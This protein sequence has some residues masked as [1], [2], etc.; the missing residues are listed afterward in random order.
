MWSG[1]QPKCTTR[2]LLK[3]ITL[4]LS[5]KRLVGVLT[6]ILTT[7]M[8]NR[9][10]SHSSD[11]WY[12]PS[13]WMSHSIRHSLAELQATAIFK[14]GLSVLTACLDEGTH[15]HSKFFLS[16]LIVFFCCIITGLWNRS[17][18]ILWDQDKQHDAITYANSH[19][20]SQC[21]PF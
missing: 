10:D 5:R 12:L 1:Y 3:G 16:W 21:I 6:S 14:H 2:T 19:L 7:L 4:R 8:I 9:S 15:N 20:K 18:Q 13:K 11:I 17:A